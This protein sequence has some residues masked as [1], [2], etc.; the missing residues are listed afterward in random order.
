VDLIGINW[1]YINILWFQRNNEQLGSTETE[2]QEQRRKKLI[3]DM[4]TI[5]QKYT[6]LPASQRML[7]D[8]DEATLE[9]LTE[10]QLKLYLHGAEILIKNHE[11]PRIK[12]IRRYFL[13]RDKTELDLGEPTR[14]K[15]S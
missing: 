14:R 1:K 13:C 7:I 12:G 2:K 6:D 8:A 3:N 11:K 9:T 15:N 4:K 10:S 5:Q